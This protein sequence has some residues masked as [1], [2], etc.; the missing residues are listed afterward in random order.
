[1]IDR[2]HGTP[3]RYDIGCRCN[4]CRAA[5]AQ[6]A[7]DYRRRVAYGR[8]VPKSIPNVG[9]Q[10]RIEALQTLGWSMR[11]L[12]RMLGFHPD[13]LSVMLTAQ[14]GVSP[15]NAARVAELYDRLWDK[16]APTRTKGERITASRTKA[17]AT[18]N[19]YLPPLAWDDD[20]IDDPAAQPHTPDD[21]KREYIPCGTPA[22]ARR[23]YRN[24][25]PLDLACR[26]AD[27]RA[28]NDRA[29]RRRAA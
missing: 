14:A 4:P 27:R 12:S 10:R 6:R 22:A 29:A 9:T 7:R 23:H 17:T 18:R 5:H 16:P 28:K 26:Q 2:S 25:E 13:R 15:R 19:G 21:G 1:M 24:G 11:S 20:E 3:R 8:Q